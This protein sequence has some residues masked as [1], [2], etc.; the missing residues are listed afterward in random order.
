MTLA[1]CPQ[2]Q[3][4]GTGKLEEWEGEIVG[5][6]EQERR[7]GLDRMWEVDEEQLDHRE[8]V[9]GRKGRVNL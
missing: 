4:S 6:R 5:F 1:T 8:D 9:A 2:L 3:G 7:D